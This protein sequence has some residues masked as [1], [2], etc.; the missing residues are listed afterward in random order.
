V[1]LRDRLRS[2]RDA[3][4]R[5][6]FERSLAVPRLLRAFADAHPDAVFVEIGANDGLQHDHLRPFIGSHRW[7][8]VMVEPVP[9][10][11]ERLRRNYAGVERVALENAA[12]GDRD[13]TLPFFFLV[14]APE[15]ERRLMPDWYDGIGS[16][17]RASV[18]GHVVHIPDIEERIVRQDVPTLTFDSLCRRHGLEHVDLLVVDT[19]GYDWEIIRRVDLGAWRPELIVY[20]HF[21]LSPG[22]RAACAEHLRAH[23]YRTLEEGFDTMCLRDGA[24]DRLERFWQRLEPAVAGVSVHDER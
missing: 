24:G 9:Y 20:E 8:G 16:F 13:G 14:D 2:A 4:R 19:E 10:I 17:S 12:I 6:R 1:T 21:H 7:R 15:D 18:A 23:G 11:F 22:D 5:R 3:V